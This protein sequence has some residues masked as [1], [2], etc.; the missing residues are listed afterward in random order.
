VATVAVLVGGFGTGEVLV[1]AVTAKGKANSKA[2]KKGKLVMM[3]SMMSEPL[4]V[5]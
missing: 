1:W 5:K 4:T 3:K 2:A